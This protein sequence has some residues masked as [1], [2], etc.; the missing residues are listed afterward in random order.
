MLARIEL[1]VNHIEKNSIQITFDTVERVIEYLIISLFF[2]KSYDQNYKKETS[3]QTLSKTVELIISL[4]SRT[5][6]FVDLH[7]NSQ[8]YLLLENFN[9]FWFMYF[10][11]DFDFG[12]RFTFVFLENLERKTR[13]DHQ[14]K[15]EN[16]ESTQLHTILNFLNDFVDLKSKDVYINFV[17]I[18]QLDLIYNTLSQISKINENYLIKITQKAFST[19]FTGDIH[20]LHPK[21]MLNF[22]TNFLSVPDIKEAFMS[23]VYKNKLYLNFFVIDLIRSFLDKNYD[24]EELEV[25]SEY[26]KTIVKCLVLEQDIPD[27]PK[28]TKY[29]LQLAQE[30]IRNKSIFQDVIIV[31]KRHL[32]RVSSEYH[33]NLIKHLFSS[34]NLFEKMIRLYKK[35]KVNLSRVLKYLL[36]ICKHYN[37]FTEISIPD[38]V[39]KN[40]LVADEFQKFQDVYTH[41]INYIIENDK[42]ADFKDE[43]DIFFVNVKSFLDNV[44]FFNLKIGYNKNIKAIYYALKVLKNC[45]QL[46]PKTLNIDVEDFVVKYILQLFEDGKKMD[47]TTKNNLYM[48]FNDYFQYNENN[49][50]VLKYERKITK[51]LLNILKSGYNMDSLLTDPLYLNKLLEMGYFIFELYPIETFQDLYIRFIHQG[52]SIEIPKKK[53]LYSDLYL[54][55]NYS[56]GLES[57]EINNMIDKIHLKSKHIQGDLKKIMDKIAETGDNPDTASYNNLVRNSLKLFYFISNYEDKLLDKDFLSVIKCLDKVMRSSYE[58]ITKVARLERL[59]IEM[60]MLIHKKKNATSVNSALIFFTIFTGAAEFKL[61]S[62][63]DKYIYMGLFNNYFQRAQHKSQILLNRDTLEYI[64]DDRVKRA[65]LIKLEKIKIEKENL[66]QIL[67]QLNLEEIN[68]N[69]E[70]ILL[71]FFQKCYFINREEVAGLDFD[72]EVVLRKF[73]EVIKVYEKFDE[74]SPIDLILLKRRMD[75]VK[76]AFKSFVYTDEDKKDK[77][78]ENI[79]KFSNALLEKLNSGTN[80]P[81]LKKRIDRQLYKR[82]L[83]LI[84]KFYYYASNLNETVIKPPLLNCLEAIIPSFGERSTS[85]ETDIFKANRSLLLVM[86]IIRRK[87]DEVRIAQHEDLVRKIT[88]LFKE[89]IIVTMEDNIQ[90]SI[91]EEKM[92]EEEAESLFKPIPFIRG[93]DLD[94][95]KELSLFLFVCLTKN[96]L[97][98]EKPKKNPIFARIDN[99]IDKFNIG[100]LSQFLFDKLEEEFKETGMRYDQADVDE[101]QVANTGSLNMKQKNIL[102]VTK[103]FITISENLKRNDELIDKEIKYLVF[104]IMALKKQLME[105]LDPEIF[106]KL[107]LFT[108]LGNMVINESIPIE[109]KNDLLELMIMF[110]DKTQEKNS[111]DPTLTE[112]FLYFY[113]QFIFDKYPEI[114]HNYFKVLEMMFVLIKYEDVVVNEYFDK[115]NYALFETSTEIV[116]TVFVGCLNS[117]VAILNHYEVNYDFEK[118]ADILYTFLK[119]NQRNMALQEKTQFAVILA[120]IDMKIPIDPIKFSNITYFLKFRYKNE[121]LEQFYKSLQIIESIS[122]KYEKYQAYMKRLGFEMVFKAGMKNFGKSKKMVQLLGKLFLKYTYLVDENKF[123]MFETLKNTLY[124]IEVFYKAEMKESVFILYK[125]LINASLAKKNAEYMLK[126]NLDDTILNYFYKYDFDFYYLVLC[127]LFNLCFILEKEDGNINDVMT[128]K[129]LTL[130]VTIFDDALEKRNETVLN[131]I[132]DLFISFIQHNNLQFFTLRIVKRIKLT[133][134]FYYETP[135]VIIKFLTIIKDIIIMGSTAILDMLVDNFDLVYLYHIHFRNIKNKKINALIKT[136]IHNLLECRKDTL[137]EDDLVTYGVPE[138]IIHSFSLEDPHNVMIVNM[139]II[140]LSSKYEK[141]LFFI[142]NHF[143]CSMKIILF[144]EEREFNDEVVYYCLDVLVALYGYFKDMELLRSQFYFINI[145]KLVDMIAFYKDNEDYLLVLIKI[146]QHGIADDQEVLNDFDNDMIDVF[147]GILERRDKISNKEIVTDVYQILNNLNI[148]QSFKNKKAPLALN[149]GNLT[150]E[151]REFL[152]IGI[153]LVAMFADKLHKGAILKYNFIKKKLVLFNV[154]YHDKFKDKHK[155]RTSILSKRLEDIDSITDKDREYLDNFFKSY[156]KKTIRRELY[157]SLKFWTFHKG[158][159]YMRDI[160]LIFDNEFKCRKFK[161][162]MQDLRS[163]L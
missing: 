154:F 94:S 128:N 48:H 130:I 46:A 54:L 51:L 2:V 141:C 20:K 67:L 44:L 80:N 119:I 143:I 57:E 140:A 10:D 62:L 90:K 43:I 98:L 91:V 28:L 102:Y 42:Y 105:N 12:D 55:M 68:K 5:K 153:P 133:L 89:E 148:Q 158:N 145:K 40:M 113:E 86:K 131:E 85:N 84:K 66:N 38:Y 76:I 116:E 112:D 142:K 59:Y 152:T 14:N 70:I 95:L 8:I 1:F 63:V 87:Y 52:L 114:K 64:K 123:E 41:F 82:E 134:N 111:V 92:N 132:I 31:L 115:L 72:S 33:S 23:F 39:I 74:L 30:N 24:F 155:K 107:G 6:S 4:F 29:I 47:I 139:K 151:D 149:D 65:T 104:G 58:V 26:L 136:I 17:I 144:H 157:T 19:S 36:I 79:T 99:Y 129:I 11:F 16:F 25:Q 96:S 71:K 161:D 120:H 146:V 100:D 138:N 106:N 73:G 160:F 18:K 88:Q 22:S 93:D 75:F 83:K 53:I 162:L 137:K 7:S 69:N 110:L 81:N 37:L 163:I 117:Y 3:I 125:C 122:E 60:Y 97:L 27:D 159:F 15:E 147:N 50:N 78:L 121:T 135:E 77:Y 150:I 103:I 32:K 156:F 127:L 49:K 56:Y 124:F 101:N 118:I 35:E 108:I 61:S 45:S 13:S 126:I 21:Y 34:A 9:L 109:Y